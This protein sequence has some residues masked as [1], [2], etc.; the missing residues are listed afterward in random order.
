MKIKKQWKDP[1]VIILVILLVFLTIGTALSG[2]HQSKIVIALDAAYGGEDTGYQG[3][4]NES[5]FSQ[6]VVE[7]LASLLEADSHFEVLLTHEAGKT[8]SVEERSQKINQ[9][10]P[11]IVLSI[12]ASGTP[13]TSRSGQEIYVDIPSSS[14]HDSSLKLAQ[15]IAQS[16]TSSTWTPSVDYLY[17]KPF[18]DDSYQLE[19]I[20][21]ADTTDYQ[22]ET[23]ELMEKCNVPVVISDQIYV[24]NQSD[25]D[26]WA[27]E[28][29]YQK[30]AECYYSA[31]KNYYGIEN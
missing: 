9:E 6:S 13:D 12:Q 19:I 29:N 28:S 3:I 5:D 24:T 18:D 10:Q 16:F 31:I 8:S 4:I 23:W 20:D 22:L 26:T 1:M 14:T 2:C 11:D 25:I 17:Y 27:S 21:S 30:A 7:K 15:A